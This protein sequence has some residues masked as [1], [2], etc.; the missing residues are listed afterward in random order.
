MTKFEDLPANTRALIL[1]KLA[2][3]L[4]GQESPSI[5]HLAKQ[6]RTDLM[7]VWRA[8]V[9][10]QTN[11]FAQFQLRRCTRH[12]ERVDERMSAQQTR[13]T[14]AEPTAKTARLRPGLEIEA[15]V[16]PSH[17]RGCLRGCHLSG[18]ERAFR[19]IPG[20]VDSRAI[21]AYTRS[22]R[23]CTGKIVLQTDPDQCAQMKFD[24]ANGQLIE[25]LKPCEKDIRF[26]EHGRA[27]P[28]GTV[29]RLDAISKSFFGN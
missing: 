23:F 10:R 24:N 15:L 20:T 21:S 12:N 3:E 19:G 25:H 8:S 28:M 16:R 17:R 1:A 27:M 11:P 26:D 22:K 29:H 14:S 13:I 9:A 2:S 7:G 6:R 18:H 5:Y 4:H